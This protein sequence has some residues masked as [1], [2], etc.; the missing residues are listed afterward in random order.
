V[1]TRAV[2]EDEKVQNWNFPNIHTLV[3]SFDDI[4]AK[5]AS[6]NYTKP[7]RRCMGLSRSRIQGERTSG[8]LPLRYECSWAEFELTLLI[9]LAY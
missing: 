3:H 5:G 6:R 8:T 4:E 9:D 7:M 1:Y 2:P